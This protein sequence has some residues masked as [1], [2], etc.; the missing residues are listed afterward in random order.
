MT[1]VHEGLENKEFE[2][3]DDIVSISVCRKSGKLPQ[4]GCYLDVRGGSSAVY[5][6]YFDIENVP[7]TICDHHTEFGQVVLPDGEEN[8]VTDD[9][10]YVPPVPDTESESESETE[11]IIISPMGPGEGNVVY[12]DRFNRPERGPGVGL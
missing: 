1:K 3:P 5:E 9:S 6:E 2:K 7:D 12:D 8:K 11:N 10:L 4:Q